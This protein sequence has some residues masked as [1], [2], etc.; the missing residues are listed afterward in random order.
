LRDE[1]KISYA[2]HARTE[3]STLRTAQVA[4]PLYASQYLT[5]V[6]QHDAQTPPASVSKRIDG[7]DL[8]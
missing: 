6:V 7:F 8:V 4:D 1:G 2:L 3:G 5:L